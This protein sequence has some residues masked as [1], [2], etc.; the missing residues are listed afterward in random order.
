MLQFREDGSF[1]QPNS[2]RIQNETSSANRRPCSEDTSTRNV[3]M[4]AE[5]MVTEADMHEK[6]AY[7]TG[8]GTRTTGSS[9]Q[10]PKGSQREAAKNSDVH[11]CSARRG[12]PVK[13]RCG[14]TSQMT[15]STQQERLLSEGDQTRGHHIEVGVA[16]QRRS[17]TRK[18]RKKKGRMKCNRL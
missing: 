10:Q 9:K 5:D 12:S 7:Q 11:V 1:G 17:R 3:N 16:G 4:G 18:Q 6:E 8:R 2:M 13:Q 15:S 14:K